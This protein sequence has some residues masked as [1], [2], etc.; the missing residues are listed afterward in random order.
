[1]SEEL[2]H[3]IEN[4]IAIQKRNFLRKPQPVEEV[5]KGYK[6]NMGDVARKSHEIFKREHMIPNYTRGVKLVESQMDWGRDPEKMDLNTTFD[7][8]IHNVVSGY[9]G[10]LENEHE[11]DESYANLIKEFE[12]V[13]RAQV[14]ASLRPKVAKKPR[15]VAKS[16]VKGKNRTDAYRKLSK[17]ELIRLLVSTEDELAKFI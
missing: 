16:V 10:E 12:K 1:M 14:S 17:D 15:T 6:V 11:H 2:V 5:L 7:K 3:L 4:E 8:R 13:K 9:N